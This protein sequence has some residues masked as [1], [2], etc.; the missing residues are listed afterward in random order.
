MM[1]SVDALCDYAVVRDA[2]DCFEFL[3]AH[4]VEYQ[5]R[6]PLVKVKRGKAFV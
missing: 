6:G 5:I 1:Y 2:I 3:Q 4:C